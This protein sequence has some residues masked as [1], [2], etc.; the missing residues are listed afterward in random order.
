M[1][2]RSRAHC[3]W[4]I[5]EENS[6][7]S[8]A[9]IIMYCQ[10]CGTE[11]KENAK[12]CLECGTRIKYA[13]RSSEIEVNQRNRKSSSPSVGLVIIGIL[14][15][16]VMYTIPFFHVMGTAYTLSSL[17]SLCENPFISALGGSTCQGYKMFFFIG[18]FIG[19]ILIASGLLFA[20]ENRKT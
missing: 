13:R 12:F 5:P 1:D 3:I 17:A 11:N 16:G 10:E 8:F 19:I 9:V 14:I 2:A 6:K 7:K 4:N 18:W 15:I 20:M